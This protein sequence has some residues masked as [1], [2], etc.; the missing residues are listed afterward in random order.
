MLVIVL[1][2]NNKLG[3]ILLIKNIEIIII[4]FVYKQGIAQKTCVS[5]CYDYEN[6]GH[7]FVQ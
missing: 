3:Y 4:M 5:Y 6:Y 2:I 7:V 1:C